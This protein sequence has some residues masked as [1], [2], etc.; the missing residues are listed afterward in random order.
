MPVF[1]LPTGREY[2]RL[3]NRSKIWLSTPS[4]LDLVGTRFYEI[5]A[6]K[7]LLFCNRSDAYD[8]LFEDKAHCVMFDPDLSDFDDRLF[9]YLDHEDERLAIVEA[10]HAH[11]LK[12]HTW[13]RRIEQFTDTVRE[14]A[15]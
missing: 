11:V 14:R 3:L 13:D 6:S 10:A 4:A 5:M 12:H 7:T 9:Y 15:L 1:R 8:G 2:A